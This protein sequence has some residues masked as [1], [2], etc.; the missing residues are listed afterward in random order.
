VTT[1]AEPKKKA[2]PAV[3]SPAKPGEPGFDWSAEYPDED[4]FVYTATDGRTVGM[5]SLKGDRKPTMGQLRRISKS[6]GPDQVWFVIERVCSPAALAVSDDFY[7]E[8]YA[9]MFDAWSKWA[10]SSAGES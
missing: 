8:E 1:V 5:A 3:V 9:K 6:P 7:D 10:N 4:F 2:K